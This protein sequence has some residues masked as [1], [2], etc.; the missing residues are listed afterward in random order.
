MKSSLS[1]TITRKVRSVDYFGYH[2][3]LKFNGFQSTYKTIPGG[4]LTILVNI[5]FFIK[6]YDNLNQMISFSNDT[7]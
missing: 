3:H 1:K 2:Y 7:V 4:I 6:S 5:I